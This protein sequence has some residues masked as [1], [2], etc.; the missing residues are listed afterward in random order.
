MG[1]I[2]AQV[3]MH[4]I[5]PRAD[6]KYCELSLSLK[7]EIRRCVKLRLFLFMYIVSEQQSKP[8]GGG[9]HP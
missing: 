8:G 6:H 7:N 1:L 9:A 4:A 3:E 5:C 2:D